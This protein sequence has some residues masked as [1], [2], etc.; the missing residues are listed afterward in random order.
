[1]PI[2]PP[3]CPLYSLLGLPP[4]SPEINSFLS[5]D[6]KPDITTL[7][8]YTYY[9][10]KSMG[11]SFC[12]VSTSEGLVLD[13]VDVYNG[14]TKEGFQPYTLSHELPFELKTDTRAFEIVTLL[15]EPDRKGG[16]A[17][18]T[19]SC[20]IEYTFNTEKESGIVIQLHGFEWEDREMGWTSFTLY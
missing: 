18:S 16:G 8:K 12:Y 7:S 5:T 10:Y 15:G 14:I 6:I 4:T 17:R 11:L 20:W 13:A 1:M 9:A 2:N 3:N 19:L